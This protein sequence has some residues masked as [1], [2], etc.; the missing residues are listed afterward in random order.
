MDAVDF[1]PERDR[2]FAVGDLVNRGP[3]SNEAIDRLER[4]GGILCATCG[5]HEA[6]T[7]KRLLYRWQT[8]ANTTRGW[9]DGTS[10]T[11]TG[12]PS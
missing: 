4:P 5:N 10:G 8:G 7:L 11:G 2:L 1:D 6:L 3:H 12:H 9:L